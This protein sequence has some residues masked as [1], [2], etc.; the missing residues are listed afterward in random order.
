MVGK[1]ADDIDHGSGEGRMGHERLHG[2]SEVGAA[3]GLAFI[4]DG[5]EDFICPGGDYLDVDFQLCSALFL[6]ILYRRL[7]L[8]G[9]RLVGLRDACL[10][11]DKFPI[12]TREGC[13]GTWV[14]GVETGKLLQRELSGKHQGKANF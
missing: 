1:N 14:R 5:G 11:E 10:G 8:I 2:D 3:G 7:Y 6:L 4:G 9:C 13:S 12:T